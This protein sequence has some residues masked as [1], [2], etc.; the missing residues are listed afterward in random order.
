VSYAFAPDISVSADGTL[1]IFWNDD[2]TDAIQYLRSTDGGETFEPVHSVVS[3]LVG[4]RGHL[5]VTNGWPHF[6]HGKFRVLTL[7]A[8]CAGQGGSVVVARAA[9]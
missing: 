5:P 3:G 9:P 7:V 6:D 2:G 8:S 4:L 1:H